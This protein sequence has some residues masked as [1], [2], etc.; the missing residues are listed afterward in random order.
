M[1]VAVYLQA[2]SKLLGTN[3]KVSNEKGNIDQCFK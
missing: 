3:K 2:S 1:A